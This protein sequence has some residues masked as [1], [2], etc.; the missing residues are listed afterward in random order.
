MSCVVISY[1]H[2]AFDCVFIM[3][4]TRFR[5]NPHSAV[6]RISR[7]SLLKTGAISE[8]EVT[9]TRFELKTTEFINDNS[10]I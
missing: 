5:V 7:N 1:P 4:H 6:A 2:A 9:A 10:T 8:I 3:S